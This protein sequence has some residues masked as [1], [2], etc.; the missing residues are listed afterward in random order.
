M[1]RNMVRDTVL[2][3]LIQMLLDGLALLLNVFLN[4]QLGAEAIGIL[5][6][7][8]SLYRLAS[9]TASGMCFFAPAGSYQRNLA[10]VNVIP[11]WY[12]VI[13]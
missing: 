3:T 5:T 11:E 12:Y 1:Q 6:L 2:L 13:A 4:A 10:G 8:A 7:T 9:V